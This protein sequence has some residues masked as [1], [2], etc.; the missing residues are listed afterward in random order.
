MNAR[1]RSTMQY[2]Q[3]EG[4]ARTFGAF[5]YRTW[6]T[7]GRPAGA[8]GREG[9]GAAAGVSAAGQPAHGDPQKPGVLRVP[10]ARQNAP[11]QRNRPAVRRSAGR[12]GGH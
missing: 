8:G 12:Q 5:P 1:K 2:A 9:E 11:R 10:A 7:R 6:A 3:V 4:P